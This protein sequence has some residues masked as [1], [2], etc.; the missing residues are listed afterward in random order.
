MIDPFQERYGPRMG[1]LLYIPALLGD[2]F[3]SAAIL[4][5]LGATI[6]VII[7]VHRVPSII[8]S[9]CVAVFYTLIGGLYSVTYT[10][11]IQLSCIFIGLV[12]EHWLRACH[13]DEAYNNETTVHYCHIA[14]V[15]WLCACLRW[16]DRGAGVTRVR[17]ACSLF[18]KQTC[19]K[20]QTS[21]QASIS[22][23]Q[24]GQLSTWLQS[25][26]FLGPLSWLLI[27]SGTGTC[28]RAPTPQ[29]RNQGKGPGYEVGP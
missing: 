25:T 5:A 7:N 15:I 14:R 12:R 16:L 21:S 24:K 29:P 1:G 23:V 3:W 2:I 19:A 4:N 22:L 10:D 8:S 18:C 28:R 26:L 9:A 11:I 6:S 27:W 17:L 20:C 13:A